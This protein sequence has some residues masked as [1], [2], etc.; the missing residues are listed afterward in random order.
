MPCRC[1]VLFLILSAR[2]SKQIFHATA[3]SLNISSN[4]LYRH[5]ATFAIVT[6]RRSPSRRIVRK[7]ELILRLT[8][9]RCMSKEVQLASKLQRNGPDRPQH[10]RPAP[11]FIAQH[12]SSAAWHS[13]CFHSCMEISER[14]PKILFSMFLFLKIAG[15]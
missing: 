7:S 6:Y 15:L 12:Y 11:C 13:L 14:F 1:F 4:F 10:D 2:T 5:S 3:A 8:S 9:Y